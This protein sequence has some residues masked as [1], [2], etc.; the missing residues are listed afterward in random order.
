MASWKTFLRSMGIHGAYFNNITDPQDI[1][2]ECFFEALHVP[3]SERET[4]EKE[5]EVIMRRLVESGI[6]ALMRTAKK[7]QM[8][9]GLTRISLNS[10]WSNKES[11]EDREN[12]KKRKAKGITFPEESAR[13]PATCKATVE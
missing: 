13:T 5:W 9:W 6:P 3:S 8:E 10:Y 11:E 1:S 7:L 2:P 12:F 4:A